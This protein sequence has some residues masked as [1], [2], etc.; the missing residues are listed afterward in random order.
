[1]SLR[2]LQDRGDLPAQAERV[3]LRH[4]RSLLRRGD[5]QHGASSPQGTQL[6]TLTANTKQM[7]QDIHAGKLSVHKSPIF[8]EYQTQ[9][10]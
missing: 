3:C 4:R 10:A 8:D 7:D 2:G 1:M 5:H 6:G 9:L